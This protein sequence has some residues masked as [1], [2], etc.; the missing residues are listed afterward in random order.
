MGQNFEQFKSNW[1]NNK[2]NI[3]K[4][5]RLVSIMFFYV[6]QFSLLSLSVCYALKYI[7]TLR[8]PSLVDKNGKICIYKENKFSK[9]TFYQRCT[10]S[11]LWADPQSAKKTY[12]LTILHFLDLLA[13]KLHIKCWWNRPYAPD[14]CLTRAKHSLPD[15]C[16][17]E[18]KILI[19]FATLFERHVRHL[20]TLQLTGRLPSLL[21]RAPTTDVELERIVMLTERGRP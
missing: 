17:D 3:R 13:Y 9:I 8:R 11:F 10:C 5:W 20:D 4:D 6:S 2:N 7:F 16:C 18:S 21:Q 15:L 12:T 14:C 1:K 19:F